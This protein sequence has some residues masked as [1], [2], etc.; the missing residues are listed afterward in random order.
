M[1]KMYGMCCQRCGCMR[2]MH[3]APGKEVYTYLQ[4]HCGFEQGAAPWPA[5]VDE[6]ARSSQLA[7]HVLPLR[8]IQV[9]HVRICRYYVDTSKLCQHQYALTVQTH[10]TMH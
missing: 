6:F 3:G 7:V 2:H 5:T 1:Y 9:P 10:L 8:I 4:L